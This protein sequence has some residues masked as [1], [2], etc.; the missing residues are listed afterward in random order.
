VFQ[1]TKL[2]LTLWVLAIHSISQAKTGLS[3]LTLRRHL[4]VSYSTAS[5]IHHKPMLVMV[6]R[7]A[8]YPLGGEFSGGAAGHNSENKV[9]SPDLMESSAIPLSFFLTPRGGLG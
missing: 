1:G 8:R 3:A 9:R 5:L 6:E 7:E 4:G 2:A